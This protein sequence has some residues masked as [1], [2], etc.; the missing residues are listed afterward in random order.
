MVSKILKN[1]LNVVKSREDALA[2]KADANFLKVVDAFKHKFGSLNELEASDAVF[3]LRKSSKALSLGL[4]IEENS[5]LRQKVNHFAE[6]KVYNLRTLSNLYFNYACVG[7]NPDRIVKAIIQSLD[8]NPTQLTSSVVTQLVH[9]AAIR[10]Q[11]LQS[12]EYKLIDII[13]K[14]SDLY[15]S[16]LDLHK[17]SELFKN[18]SKMDLHINTNRQMYPQI[19]HKLRKEFKENIEKLGED[20]VLNIVEAY[21][22]LANNFNNDLIEEFRK[23]VE[24]TLEHNAVN[25]K[26][27]FLIKYLDAQIG[28]SRY[29]LV[30]KVQENECGRSKEDH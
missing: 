10:G 13:C 5:V 17:K 18:L 29:Q 15:F 21:S 20:E 7:W 16:Q 1:S 6:Q 9:S 3:I 11:P 27:V 23:M 24:V 4:N 26:S 30:T 22:Y 2:L 8:E 25:L 28:L 12:T 19:L 14:S